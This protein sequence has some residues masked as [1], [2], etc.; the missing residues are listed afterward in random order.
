MRS[1]L[2]PPGRQ[3][4]RRTCTSRRS[5]CCSRA[6]GV[7]P[8][9]YT[10]WVSLHDWS[11]LSDDAH[12]RSACDN[13]TELF[14]DHVLLE[15]AAATP[16]RSGCSPP[17]R[18]CCSRCV[19]AH[20]LNQR[21]RAPTF[22]R[23]SALLPNITSVAAVA[24]I[25]GQL[26]GRDYGLINW[27]LGLFGVGKIDWQAGTRQLA[28][29]H[30]R[31]DHLAVDRLQ[32]A[33][34]PGRD[35]GGAARTCTRRPRSTARPASSSSA[36]SPCRRS[37]PTIIF[38]VIISTIGGMQVLAEPLLFGGGELDR[39]LRPAVP[40]ARR[41]TCTRSASAASTSATPRR[42]PG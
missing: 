5:S 27:L 30:L 26:F 25:F 33:D 35:A 15:R 29:R 9:V 31:D 12:V 11:L 39:R 28:D 37:G 14:D 7:F 32:R 21:L 19:L 22:W 6:F 24:I 17:C 23:M 4:A 41:S 3:G 34:L 38:T 13:Y 2:L 36:R 18:S 16:L 8:L 42:P 40:D 20:V 1:L 10:A